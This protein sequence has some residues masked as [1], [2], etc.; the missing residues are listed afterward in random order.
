VK[1]NALKKA[2]EEGDLKIGNLKN[3]LDNAK[4]FL[5]LLNSSFFNPLRNDKQALKDAVSYN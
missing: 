5:K 1:K 4:K 3:T 2:K